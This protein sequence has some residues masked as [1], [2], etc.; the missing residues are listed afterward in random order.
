VV[1]VDHSTV[2]VEAVEPILVETVALMA[3]QALALA[4]MLAVVAVVLWVLQ[5]AV[6]AVKAVVVEPIVQMLAVFLQRL[7]TLD[8]H[9]RVLVAVELLAILLVTQA[10]VALLDSVAVEAEPAGMAVTVEAVI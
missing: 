7:Q 6:V 4:E 8:T 5:T 2:V 3:D 10:V 9:I 1:E